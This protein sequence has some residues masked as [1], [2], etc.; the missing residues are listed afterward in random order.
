[1]AASECA[2][3]VKVGG[4]ADVVGTLPP[5]LK[6]N[7]H[8]VKVF[9]PKY[10]KIDEKAFG[11]KKLSFKLHIPVGDK[12]EAAQLK[13]AV[14]PNGTKCYFIE[15]DKYFG[16]P[17]VYGTIHGDYPDNRERFIFFSRAVLEAAKAV[18]FQ[19]DIIHCHDWQTGLIPAYLKTLYSIDGFYCNC[20]TVFT[21]HNIAYQGLFKADTIPL[22]GFSW[23]D[24][25]WDRLEYYG[26]VNLLKIALTYADMLSTVSP[27]YAKEI[28]HEEFARGMEKTLRHRAG[29][30][31]GILNGIDYNEWNP[32]TDKL[33]AS[34]F[35][36]ND[37]SGKKACKKDLQKWCG[38][39]DDESALIIGAVSRLD[40]QKGFV[41]VKKVIPKFIANNVQF[42]FLGKG[43]KNIQTVLEG[44]ARKYPSK[45]SV[46]FEFNNS[47]AHKIYAGSDA[48]LMASLFEPCGL[49]QM[50]ALS[51]GTVPV[52]NRTG[53]LFDTVKYFNPKTFEGNG[54]SFH[55]PNEE[56]LLSSLKALLKTYKNPEQWKKIIHNA[57]CANFSWDKSARM[58]GELYRRAV[59]KKKGN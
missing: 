38:L 43:D 20:A 17:E 31:M 2:P 58:Y 4:L 51:Y 10:R 7:G 44:F 28:L 46:H 23:K 12:Y 21:I 30:L 55:P 34:N 22:A 26:K 16:R 27:T 37:L 50:I 53:G 57:A 41:L 6:E 40:P 3:F 11:V 59:Q 13:T 36:K 24:F 25:T 33:I 45:V 42:V 18:G 47:L 32:A 49:G 15:N 48:F 39:P 35:S 1:M 52:V 9:L 19:P 56:N 8:E 14:S 29:D 5:Y 54:F